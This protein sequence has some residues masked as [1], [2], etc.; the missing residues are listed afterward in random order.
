MSSFIDNITRLKHLPKTR[1]TRYFFFFFC[2]PEITNGF[3]TAHL[4]GFAA[5]KSPKLRW[6]T[7]EIEMGSPG[8]IHYVV[9]VKFESTIQI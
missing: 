3:L 8:P 9:G 2:F 5:R 7:V 4:Y 1:F 6:N